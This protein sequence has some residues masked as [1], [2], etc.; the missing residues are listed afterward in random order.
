M[1][2]PL[3]IL[4]AAALMAIPTAA[5]AESADGFRSGSGARSGKEL[6][7]YLQCVPYARQVSGIQIYGDAHTWWNQAAG[8]FK[9][10]NTPKKGAVMAFRPH[11]GMKLGHVAAVSKVIDSRTILLRHSNWSPINGRRGQIENDVRAIDVSPNN[12]WSAVRVWYHPLQALG[13]TAWPIH[14]FIYGKGT[15]GGTGPVRIAAAKPAPIR[16]QPARINS[17]KAF[18]S[19]FSNLGELAKAAPVRRVA[20]TRPAPKLTKAKRYDPV[21]A[22]IARYEK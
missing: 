11:R 8:K 5:S 10:G 3:S 14:G 19:A 9:R 21:A 2:L 16:V 7:P 13:K 12:D 18:L 20:A 22:A 6:P 1:K 17:S 15:L 4:T